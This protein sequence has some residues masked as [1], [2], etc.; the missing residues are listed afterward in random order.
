MICVVIA[1]INLLKRDLYY[2][3]CRSIATIV[4]VFPVAAVPRRFP[5]EIRRYRRSLYMVIESIQRTPFR[6][7]G[8]SKPW[9]SRHLRA[10]GPL[11]YTC[12]FRGCAN[13]SIQVYH[14]KRLDD[15]LNLLG[16]IIVKFQM[17][18]IPKAKSFGGVR[19][20]SKVMTTKRVPLCPL[21]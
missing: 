13:T 7:K 10:P 15:Y 8:R 6:S 5:K 9:E 11:F 2:S 12:A 17:Q 16:S 18:G 20:V 1:L 3:L 14:T 4:G 19:A 21:H